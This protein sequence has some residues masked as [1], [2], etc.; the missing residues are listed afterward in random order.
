MELP[1]VRDT[2]DETL[3]CLSLW[4]DTGNEVY[5]SLRRGND[6]LEREHLSAEESLG[7]E[8]VQSLQG[9]VNVPRACNAAEPFPKEILCRLQLLYVGWFYSDR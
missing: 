9:C 7:I 6:A 8:N 5:S 2:L 1:L 4:C 3:G